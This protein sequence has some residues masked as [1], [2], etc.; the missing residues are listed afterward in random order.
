MFNER[1]EQR[2]KG[3]RENERE[4]KGKYQI[5][6]ELK[7]SEEVMEKEKCQRKREGMER[8]GE[9]EG[10]AQPLDQFHGPVIE[11]LEVVRRECDLVWLVP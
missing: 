6:D 11:L 10:G 9:K 3:V 7:K 1:E 4:K 8:G 2:R 5:K